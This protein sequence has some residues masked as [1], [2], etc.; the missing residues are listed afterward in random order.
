[1]DGNRG[2]DDVAPEPGWLAVFP[3]LPAHVAP[4]IVISFTARLI[5]GEATARGRV[6]RSPLVALSG[7]CGKSLVGTTRRGKQC[8]M[9]THGM[10]GFSDLTE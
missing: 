2:H 10:A 9:F 8:I 7:R 4:R 5:S 1:M 6:L 3:G